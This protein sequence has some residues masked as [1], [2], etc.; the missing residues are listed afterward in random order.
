MSDPIVHFAALLFIS[1][2]TASFIN[3]IGVRNIFITI[4]IV[5]LLAGI[6]ILA[7]V[8]PGSLVAFIG[9]SCLIW[10]CNSK[11]ADAY[12]RGLKGPRRS[13]SANRGP[14]QIT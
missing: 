2:V 5:L 12:L 8:S 6:A 13:G 11:T 1:L 9:A 7:L 14:R 3:Q 10:L 4:I